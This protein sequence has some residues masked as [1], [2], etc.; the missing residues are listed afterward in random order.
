LAH[1]QDDPFFQEEQQQQRTDVG[2]ATDIRD[3]FLL[4]HHLLSDSGLL[5]VSDHLERLRGA[6]EAKSTGFRSALRQLDGVTNVSGKLQF[7]K[8]TANVTRGQGGGNG[9]GF[10][11]LGLTLPSAE[12]IEAAERE[13]QSAVTMRD[14]AAFR[15]PRPDDVKEG[16]SR[17][18]NDRNVRPP[19]PPP[20]PGRTPQ[21]EKD[22]ARPKP[23]IGGLFM[24]GLS[25]LAAAATQPSDLRT[26][27][28]WG[29][30]GGTGLTPPSSPTATRFAQAPTNDFPT[31]Y[32]REE[33]EKSI[34]HGASEGDFGVVGISP[35]LSAPANTHLTHH[36]ETGFHAKCEVN[37]ET[38]LDDTVEDDGGWSDEEFDFE[39]TV[40]T[41]FAK[42]Q[43]ITE[44]KEEKVA[45]ILP[46]RNSSHSKK[47]EFVTYLQQD[48]PMVQPKTNNIF[49]ED[50]A[51]ALK[52][53]IKS[54]NR[55]MV[56][57]GRL[58]RWTPLNEDPILRQRL[59]EVMV[60]TL[61]D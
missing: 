48:Q 1:D 43:V 17:S 4:N 59:M 58:K 2:D 7:L 30:E 12:E 26:E 60:N 32:R 25:R 46:Q 52:E 29:E 54:E 28:K 22:V 40:N 53:K 50:F 56:E 20:P 31:L 6:A 9:S 61:R 51:T 35:P 14:D 57:S 36:Q 15:F 19:P 34:S 47:E 24:S 23:I 41:D 27:E 13:A 42:Q 49:S 37:R 44:E 33:C 5:A 11:G 18:Y 8:S 45:T 10:L 21:T 3:L 16:Y 39:E 55:E 38:V